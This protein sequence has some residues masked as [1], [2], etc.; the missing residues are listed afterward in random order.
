MYLF[1][2]PARTKLMVAATI[3]LAAGVFSSAPHPAAAQVKSSGAPALSP[4]LAQVKA[5]LDKYQ[6]P[7]A[8]VRD[9]FLSTVSCIDFPEGGN[10]GGVPY[11][12][13]AMG[14]H[15]VNMG[16]VGPT[17][18]PAKP[19]VL[20]YEPV[21]DKLQLVAAEWFMPAQLVKE[22]PSV[23]GQKL[24][25]PMD[26]HEPIMPAQLRHYDLHVWLWRENPNGTFEPTN[27][28]VK[29]PAGGYTHAE[30]PHKH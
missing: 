19:Q 18:D 16:N 28:A 25:G 17:L 14:V 24:Q 1:A 5:A 3:G 29:C 22:A 23:L 13:G 11:K 9:G 12:P 26:G 6:D 10:D 27:L 20:M 2:S 8:A 15:F 30:R 21:G 4:E 7:M